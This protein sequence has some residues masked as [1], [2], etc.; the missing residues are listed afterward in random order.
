MKKEQQIS[1]KEREEREQSDGMLYIISLV[2]IGIIAAVIMTIA[3][4]H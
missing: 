1:D 3:F 2:S 4:K